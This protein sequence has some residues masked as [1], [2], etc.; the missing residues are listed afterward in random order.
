MKFKNNNSQVRLFGLSPMLFVI[1]L[2]L[3]LALVTGA[4]ELTGTTHFFHKDKLPAVIG[5]TSGGPSGGPS[6]STSQSS[7]SKTS[8]KSAT[9][10]SGGNQTSSSLPLSAPYG[11]FVSNHSPNLSGH[12]A[13]SS[14]TSVCNTTPGAQCY[15]KFTNGTS[16][17]K[18]PTKTTGS[19]GAAY[20]YWDVGKNNLS[21]G[22][23][24]I[25]VTA[26]LNG[27]TKTTQDP[28]ALSVKK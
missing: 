15:I 17:T 16:S 1:L 2:L 4:L 14:E 11:V 21:P 7:G 18:L 19:D 9:Q 13:P 23:W 20:W 24:T 12:P 10:N 3:V 28:I 8:A 27:H 22:D 5:T 26:T 6:S 25:I